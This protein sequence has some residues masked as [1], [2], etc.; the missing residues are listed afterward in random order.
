[1]LYIANISWKTTKANCDSKFYTSHK[2]YRFVAPGNEMIPT[3]PPRHNQQRCGTNLP[4]GQPYKNPTSVYGTT[5][6]HFCYGGAGANTCGRFV[7]NFK[8]TL[9][10][11]Y[12]VY[13]IEFHSACNLRICTTSYAGP[14]MKPTSAS[15]TRAP[16]GTPTH[17]PTRAPTGRPTHLPTG[18]P[19]GRPTHAPTIPSQCL[20]YT[21]LNEL[22]RN[23]VYRQYFLE[24]HQ[25]KLR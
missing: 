5:S 12:Y 9:C 8:T 2:L 1:M 16:T 25:G 23:V 3:S 20:H 18:A 22:T 13:K 15:P 14:T 21:S 7:R 17:T 11:G 4:G 24:D 10:D 6:G 19:T